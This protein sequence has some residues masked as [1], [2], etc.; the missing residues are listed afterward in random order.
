MNG[1]KMHAAVYRVKTEKLFDSVFILQQK[2]WLYIGSFPDIFWTPHLTA[3]WLPQNLPVSN[4]VWLLSQHRL[5]NGC[6]GVSQSN[7]VMELSPIAKKILATWVNM[8]TI[9]KILI[10]PIQLIR[11]LLDIV[12]ISTATLKCSAP[13][14]ELIRLTYI[15]YGLSAHGQGVI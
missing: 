6:G 9:W 12:V 13:G 10:L 5:H 2:G 7:L 14:E 1:Q 3:A 8:T 4:Q 11:K 15:P